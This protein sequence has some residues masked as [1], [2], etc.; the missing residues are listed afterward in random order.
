MPTCF[1]CKEIL[2]TIKLLYIHFE[3]KHQS[4]LEFYECVESDCHKRKFDTFESL[5][6]HLNLH[7]YNRES[8]KS[9]TQDKNVGCVN[10]LN[11]FE[12]HNDNNIIQIVNCD[13]LQATILSKDKI[14]DMQDNAMDNIASFFAKLS[15]NYGL[16]RNHVQ[17][18]YQDIQKLFFN[19]CLKQIE[20]CINSTP[21]LDNNADFVHKIQSICQNYKKSFE[22]MSTEYRRIK[23]FTQSKQY[24]APQPYIIGHDIETN[25]SDSGQFI[26]LRRTLELFFQIPNALEDIFS[27]MRFLQ[28]NVSDRIYNY[29]QTDIWKKNVTL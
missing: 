20:E 9:I 16:P 26:S 15:S 24:V 4:Q 22:V 14:P 8:Q 25:V 17:N 21:S 2:K 27:Y 12:S 13:L 18:L 5:K 6:R 10:L 29:I 7:H 11:N 28:T 3:Y 19:D 23:Y 1:I